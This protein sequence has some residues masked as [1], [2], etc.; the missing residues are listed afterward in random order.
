MFQR[1]LLGARAT[2]L[3]VLAENSPT[4]A[5]LIRFIH[6]YGTGTNLYRTNV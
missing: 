2:Q 5:Q 1:R 4:I 3:L 6:A